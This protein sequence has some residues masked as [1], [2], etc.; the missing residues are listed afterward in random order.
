MRAGTQPLADVPMP[1]PHGNELCLREASLSGGGPR[2][3]PKRGTGPTY[4]QAQV[5]HPTGTV[6]GSYREQL[7]VPKANVNA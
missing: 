2:T 7:S 1:T 4:E 6:H 5:A 3:C